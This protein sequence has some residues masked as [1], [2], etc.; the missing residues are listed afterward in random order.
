MSDFMDYGGGCG[1]GSSPCG[2]CESY[3][4]RGADM[5]CSKECRDEYE[6]TGDW[7]PGGKYSDD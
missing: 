7:G 1:L 4:R 2:N 3:P 6:G 5:F